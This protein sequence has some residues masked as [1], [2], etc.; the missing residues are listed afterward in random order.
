MAQPT[1][2]A[3]LERTI[4]A[5]A[6]MMVA[7]TAAILYAMGR[8]PI[9]TCGTVK[10]WHGVVQSAENSQH[11]LDWYSLTH[12]GHG[13]MFFAAL[14]G[15]MRALGKEW[16][17]PRRYLAALALECA[18]EI[19]ENT[20][21]IIG[22]YRSVTVDAGYFGDS[23]VNSLSDITMMSLGFLIAS[24]VS[25]TIGVAV[26]AGLELTAFA[27]IRDSLLINIIQLIYPIEALRRLQAGG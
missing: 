18:W 27:A 4:I 8:P 25:P 15:V 17:L 11:I 26:F 2:T 14:W 16:S 5:T 24:R 20:D 22:R 12:V 6:L 23:I 7:V 9:C 19:I 21:M 10:L 1:G 13:L 3:H